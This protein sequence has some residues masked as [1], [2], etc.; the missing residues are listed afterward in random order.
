MPDVIL[1]RLVRL[2][3]GGEGCLGPVLEPLATGGRRSIEEVDRPGFQRVLGANDEQA[4]PPN[5]EF[6]DLRSMPQVVG[7]CPDVRP[8]GLGHQGERIATGLGGEQSLHGWSDAIDDR[9]LIA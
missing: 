2:G 3:R 7:R 8:D 1:G 4:L 5:Q 9:T 6:Q